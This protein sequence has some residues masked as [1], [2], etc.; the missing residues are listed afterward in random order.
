MTLRGLNYAKHQF[1]AVLCG[2]KAVEAG[3][4]CLL[5]MVQGHLVALTP[6]HFE[7][8]AKTGLSRLRRYWEFRLLATRN[9]L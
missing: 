6:S 5:L 1:R 2:H 8:A 7:I 3:A 4:I 9:T